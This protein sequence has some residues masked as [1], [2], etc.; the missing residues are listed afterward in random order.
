MAYTFV[1]QK[2][3]S[4]AG[5]GQGSIAS[6]ATG[7]NIT[8]N[9]LLV[10]VVEYYSGAAKTITFSDTRTLTFVECGNVFSASKGEGKRWGYALV[11]SSGG[12]TE[13]VTATFSASVDFPGIYIAEYSG[14]A[15]VAPFTSG[16]AVGQ[17]QQAPGTGTDA[18]TST[19]T[20]TLATQPCLVFGFSSNI[21]VGFAPVA[22]TGF[23]SRTVVWVTSDSQSRPQD[24]RVTATTAV[25]ATWTSQAAHDGD[26]YSNIVMVFKEAVGGGPNLKAMWQTVL[27][28]MGY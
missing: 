5:T 19:A 25:A 16:E 23:T 28:S 14:L 11:G 9:N 18:V 6:G 26:D 12:A 17:I 15:T 2:E 13:N 24:K 20:P 3:N 4:S 27:R 7:S 21:T 10:W 22:G 8:N 1:Q